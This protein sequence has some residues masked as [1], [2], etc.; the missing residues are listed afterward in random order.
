M[1]NAAAILKQHESLKTQRA[2]QVENVWRDCFDY[3][4]PLRGNG[5][6]GNSTETADS[7]QAKQAKLLDST[8]A[9]S[10]NILASAIQAGLTPANSLW[11]GIDVGNESDEEKRWLEDS[12]TLLWENIH[13]ANFDA[14]AFECC[15][16]ICC[17][18]QFALF[19]DEDRERGGLIFHQWSLAT[20]YVSS[21]RADGRIDIVHR[22]YEL[23]ALQA[24]TEFGDTHVSERIRKSALETPDEKF[25]FVHAIYPRKPYVVGA[26]FAK[27]LPI[28]SCHIEVATKTEVRVSGY[29]EMPVI[30]PRWLRV[31]NSIYAV[32][33]MYAALPNV[34]Q[35]NELKALEL[36]SADV[37]VSGM[38]VA[39]DDGILNARTI[40]F[41][42]RK[43]IIA[44]DTDN[45]KPLQTGANFQLSQEMTA[46]LQSAIRK[47]MMA[48]QLQPQDGPQ[49]TATEVHVRVDMIRQLLG[50]IYGRLQAEYLKPLVERCFGLAYRA[51][52]FAPPP[53][54]LL[55]REFSVRYV[56]PMA[57]AQKG[58]E[59]AAIEQTLFAAGQLA[60]LVPTVM[61]QFDI[62]EAMKL[63]AEGKG[64]P[65][66][67]MRKPEEVAAIQKQRADAAQQAQQQQAALQTQQAG[68][69]AAVK[70]AAAA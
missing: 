14:E 23:T 47:V 56:S 9:D 21:T 60:P 32:G 16:D 3:T 25:T 7:A 55:G 69:E 22:E 17:A 38:W 67:I 68:A 10:A 18:G 24:V 35:L 8:A 5:L 53:E 70:Q 27:N 20:V 51:G 42:P 65:S 37:A 33:P 30:V 41:G 4:F 29:H 13:M 57:R 58:E 26:K 52:I 45:L 1:S 49:M 40:K 64:A 28:A 62:P 44:A 36:A 43:V 12:A 34:R 2:S 66:K 48:D 46:Q 63:I 6:F 31:P 50:P 54:S 39:V 15:L 19:I 11:F 61:D 59:V